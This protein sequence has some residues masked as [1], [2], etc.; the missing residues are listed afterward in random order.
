[1]P[2]PKGSATQIAKKYLR[3]ISFCRFLLKRK[4]YKS[5]FDDFLQ[6]ENPVQILKKVDFEK[7]CDL[8]SVNNKARATMIASFCLSCKSIAFFRARTRVTHYEKNE[9]DCSYCVHHDK[10]VAKTA[11]FQS[12]LRF[13]PQICV[14]DCF[15][16]RFVL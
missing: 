2:L 3:S 6:D 1:M 11:S 13:L 8:P 4:K 15:I 14:F 10:I 16:S 7:L 12:I 5:I 9:N